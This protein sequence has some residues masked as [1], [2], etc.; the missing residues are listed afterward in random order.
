MDSAATRFFSIP[1]LSLQLECLLT[2]QSIV[3]LTK[4]DRRLNEIYT[5]I[6][7]KT[8]S[9]QPRPKNLYDCPGSL[10][11]SLLYTCSATIH[12]LSCRPYSDS[13]KTL[14]DLK[15]TS[16]A[17]HGPLDDS[18]Q[19][20]PYP[21]PVIPLLSRMNN[22]MS[23]NCYSGIS[24]RLPVDLKHKEDYFSGALVV[25]LCDI[26]RFCPHLVQLHLGDVPIHSEQD[27]VLIARAMAGLG[28]LT[29][30]SLDLR[31]Y[32]TEIKDNVVPAIFFGLPVGVE[33]LDLGLYRQIRPAGMA[34]TVSEVVP[35]LTDEPLTR[36]QEPLY[37][38]T[39][40]QGMNMG[41]QDLETLYSMYAHCPALVR[42][43]VPNFHL[44]ADVQ[45]IARFIADHC[46]KLKR[47]DHVYNGQDPLA[48]MMVALI[49]A[50]AQDTLVSLDYDGAE[51]EDH[52]LGAS[53]ERHF[54]SLTEINFQGTYHLESRTIQTILVGCR[55][56]EVFNIEGLYDHEISLADAVAHQWACTRI[57]R[58]AIIINIGDIQE[59][60]KETIY[61][62]PL[63]I[64]LTDAE[65]D[66]MRLLKR[67]YQQIGSLT[68]LEFLD[69][70]IAVDVDALDD[71][72]F[73]DFRYF[74][75]PYLL[76]L[77]D[78]EAGR[79][80]Y[81]H[82][83]AGLGNLKTLQGS[84]YADTEETK[85]TMDQHLC[86]WILEHWPRLEKAWFFPPGVTPTEPF[87]WLMGHLHEVSEAL[88]AA[89]VGVLPQDQLVRISFS[90]RHKAHDKLD[91][92]ILRHCG[93]LTT[94]EFD[95]CR[96]FSGEDIKGIL[97]QCSRLK[98]L[99]AS[100]L[101]QR[102]EIA[103]SFA[104]LAEMKAMHRSEADPS[105]SMITEKQKNGPSALGRLYR[106]IRTLQELGHVELAVYLHN[107]E[108]NPTWP[109]FTGPGCLKDG[110]VKTSEPFSFHWE[111]WDYFLK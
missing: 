38:L 81:L 36:R 87:Q 18:S 106:E 80:G 99:W 35:G 26:L 43:V 70:R 52:R 91:R 8:L 105:I 93:L 2:M 61:A 67:L 17:D 21:C 44:S 89:T 22:L 30:L 51:D 32:N 39:S 12:G 54:G 40:W 65:T 46:P 72:E 86:E 69:L 58:L 19:S 14:E 6:L 29:N 9:I 85:L 102:L 103:V 73:F 3:A 34:E 27:V 24:F 13:L 110:E 95:S 63:P 104:S 83:L 82:L 111:D 33:T 62:R 37:K 7:Y 55:N 68:Q 10:E 66:R 97:R 57:R 71:E 94:I 59:L 25:Q 88:M 78:V 48:T 60:K 56:L 15:R 41:R 92:D 77:A 107:D 49:T 20:S 75:F 101:I 79:T 16:E 100:S 109:V 42:L 53:L 84:F 64:V 5:P 98:V 4:V 50:M 76:A 96:S 28:S 47:L 108:P 74:S 1:E 11:K 23:L 31:L 90:G 45:G